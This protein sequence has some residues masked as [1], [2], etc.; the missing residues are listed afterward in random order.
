MGYNGMMKIEMKNYFRFS[1]FIFF[2]VAVAHAL[3][4]I[5][6]WT[7]TVGFVEIPFLVSWL[8]V[9]IT[10]VLTIAGMSYIRKS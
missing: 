5:Y 9:F 6:G 3:R 8:A 2:L 4:L 1:V 10:V 7:V